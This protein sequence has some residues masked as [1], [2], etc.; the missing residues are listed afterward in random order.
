MKVKE[1]YRL[2]VSLHIQIMAPYELSLSSSF[3]TRVFP[4]YPYYG[5]KAQ[6][7]SYL[8]DERRNPKLSELERTRRVCLLQMLQNAPIDTGE[9]VHS[10]IFNA[11]L[12]KATGCNK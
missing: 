8:K 10:P 9:I 11:R 6:F 5:Q 1:I 2:I 7:C 4:N 12:P 3:Y